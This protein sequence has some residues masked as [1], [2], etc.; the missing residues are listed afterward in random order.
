LNI[1]YHEIAHIRIIDARTARKMRA[2]QV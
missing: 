1:C 2:F